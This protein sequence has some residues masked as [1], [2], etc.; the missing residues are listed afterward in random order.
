MVLVVGVVVVLGGEW[1][2]VVGWWWV[3]GLW[4]VVLGLNTTKTCSQKCF[5][6]F[7]LIV[8]KNQGV[9]L[10]LWRCCFRTHV[11]LMILAHSRSS[12][13]PLVFLRRHL[14]VLRPSVV[15][16][17][18]SSVRSASVR[19]PSRRCPSPLSDRPFVRPWVVIGPNR[20]GTRRAPRHHRP[21]ARRTR[22][23]CYSH[24]G[25]TGRWPGAPGPHVQPT[26]NGHKQ[27]NS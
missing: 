18:W 24:Q 26:T 27:R 7:V 21:L 23:P 22:A 19:R 16:P 1:W 2:V 25:T 8:N 15:L 5:E 17:S 4:W 12:V 14:S 6:R 3:V 13:L 9:F 10:V 20:T 11:F